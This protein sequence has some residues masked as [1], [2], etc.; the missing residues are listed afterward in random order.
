MVNL[1]Q[2]YNAENVKILISV[3]NLLIFVNYQ[4]LN[5]IKLLYIFYFMTI[6]ELK[7]LIY[8]TRVAKVTQVSTKKLQMK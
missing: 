6:E 1:D 2:K 3:L 8:N 5:I 7:K 4:F